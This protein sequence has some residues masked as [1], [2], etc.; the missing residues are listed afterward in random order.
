MSSESLLEVLL[1]L[2]GPTG[3]QASIGIPPE[4]QA[5]VDVV[6]SLFTHENIAT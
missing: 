3:E 1:L 4:G 2:P 5:S 6:C